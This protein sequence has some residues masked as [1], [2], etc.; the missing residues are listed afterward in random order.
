MAKS[1]PVMSY[2]RQHDQSPTV[3]AELRR[4]ELPHS[5]AVMPGGRALQRAQRKQNAL[6]TVAGVRRRAS[7]G[8]RVAEAT[9]L[10]PKLWIP[11]KS[12]FHLLQGEHARLKT[13]ASRKAISHGKSYCR[14]DFRLS[15]HRRGHGR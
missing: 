5:V 2:R 13:A 11:S 1:L 15:D 4:T 8:P 6:G 14:P 9:D 10:E 3:K 7:V 12:H